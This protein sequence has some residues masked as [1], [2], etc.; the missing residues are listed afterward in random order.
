MLARPLPSG[1]QVIAVEFER[2]ALHTMESA[3]GEDETKAQPDELAGADGPVEAGDRAPVE[4]G[5]D[6][7][8]ASGSS[9]GVTL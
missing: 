7:T 1:E 9:N 6:S 5:L 4:P 2:G 8:R 3:G